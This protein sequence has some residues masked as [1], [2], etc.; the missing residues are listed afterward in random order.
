MS[1]IMASSS[2]ERNEKEEILS[3][4][5]RLNNITSQEISASEL[6]TIYHNLRPGNSISLRQVSAAIQTICFCD[7]CLRDEVIDVLNEIDRRSF[8]MQGL[9]WEFEMLD[10][11]NQGTITEEQ[12]CFLLKA[13]HGN[14]AKKNTREFLSSRPIPGSRVSLQ[15][16]EIWLCNPCDLELSDESDLDVKI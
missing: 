14:Y 6:Q 15:E 12:A 16:L 3:T 13:V 11:E 10:G 5:L 9:K 4:Y 7:L 2:S 8:L 1:K